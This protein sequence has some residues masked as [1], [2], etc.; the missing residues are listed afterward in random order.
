ML[1]Q[2]KHQYDPALFAKF[3]IK[4]LE[5]ALK[6]VKLGTAA[7]FDGVYPKFIRNCGEGLKE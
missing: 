4:E 1:V 6:S 3:N 5:S 2:R 7:G